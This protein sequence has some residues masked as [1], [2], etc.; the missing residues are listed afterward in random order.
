MSETSQP[1]TSRYSPK[2]IK[3]V[4]GNEQSIR[5][6]RDWIK[7]WDTGTPKQKAVFL[8]GPPGIGK[9]CS[10][11]AIANELGLDL[12]EVNASDF[13]TKKKLEALIGR[14][15]MQRITITG[16]KRLILFDE[17]E[18]VSGVQDR[19]G[20]AAIA[21]MIKTSRVPIVMIAA[22]IGE[23]WE[24]KFRSLVDLS[25]LIEYDPVPWNEVCKKI[26]IIMA[27]LGIKIDDDVVEI[28][29]DK[30]GG[31]LRSTI[32][33]L[34]SISRGKTHVTNSDT[35][36]MGYRDRKDYTPDALMK[37]FSAKTLR[38]AR[39]IISKAHIN[40]DTLFDWIYE[41]LPTV[42]DD[43]R[44]LSEGME[45]LSRADI[46]QTQGKK[47]QDYRLL[48]YMFNSMTGG[49]ALARNKS[50]GTGLLKLIEK[51]VFKLGY[52][53]KDFQVMEV[54]DGIQI[55]PVKYLKNDWRKVNTAFRDIGAKYIRG[56]GRWQLSYFRPPGLKWRY[57]K[58]YHSRRRQ[59]SVAE[60]VAKLCH[61]GRNE[62]VA[63]V[64][65]LIKV[66]YKDDKKMGK[67]LTKW[68]ELDDKEVT[69]IKKS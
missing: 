3:D 59:R 24:D 66:I 23:A 6:L 2:T 11:I 64:L 37:M 25:L 19:G 22:S 56:A 51:T 41:N 44:E 34:E 48:K 30:C 47:S 15:I 28:L 42:L 63:E 5:Q 65:P 32:N 7:S 43:P 16:K 20:I 69:W 8:Y 21:K 18:G 62:A 29:A 45:A 9:T 13:R 27:D 26:N 31:D 52:Q 40:Y 39:S 17:M 53:L 12:L 55:K 54:K 50:Q 61:I 58:T 49:V 1:W 14:S 68:L 36:K 4:A 38:D 67:N 60:K 57:I 10:V 33:D 46:Y 35:E